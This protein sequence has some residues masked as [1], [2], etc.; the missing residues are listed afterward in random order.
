MS[1]KIDQRIVEMSFENAK[2]EKGIKQSQN[3]LKEFSKALKNSDINEDFA[4]L[5]KSVSSLSGHFSMLEQIGIGALRRIGEQAVDAGA[6][7]IKSLSVDQLAAGWNK[8]EEK[9]DAVQTLISAGYDMTAVNQQMEQLMWFSDETSYS[10]SDMSN[11]MG[12]FVAA[13]VDL[14]TS[15]RAMQGIATWAAH[16]GKNSQ[17][18]SIAM[19]NLSQAI[20]MGYVDTL[21]WRSIM[22]QNMNTKMF[23]EIAIG[24]AE[25]TGAIKEGQVTIQNFDSNL[26]DKWFTNDVLLKTLEQYSMYAEKVREVQEEMGFDTAN[27]AMEYMEEHGEE[28]ADVLSQIGNAAFK[29]AQESKKFSDSIAATM[30]AVSSGWMRTYEII[31]GEL[32]EAKERFT[33]LTEI[34]WTVFASGAEHRNEMLLWLKEAGGITN[35][36]QG[37]KNVAVALLKILKPISTAMDQIFPPKTKEQWLAITEAFKDFTNSLIIS[38]E[39]ADKVRRTFAGFFAVVDIGYRVLKFLGNA[40]L[41]LA[42]VF[43][44]LGSSFLDGTAS[45]GDFLVKIDELLKSSQLLNYALLAVKVGVALLRNGVQSVLSTI[46]EFVTGL[47]NAEDPLQYLADAGSTVFSGLIDGIKMASSWLTGKLSKALKTVSDL[48]KK[49]EGEDDSTFWSDILTVLKDIVEYIGGKG[50]EAFENFGETIKNL[51]F[52][53]IATFVVGGVLLILVKQISDLTGAMTGMTTAV[54]GAINAFTKKFL[55]YKT[56]T[57][58]RD[59]GYA[60]GI[61]A[62]SIWLLSK[63]PAEELKKSLLG[64]AAAMGIFVTA[65]GLLTG[66]QVAASKLMKNTEMVTSGFGLVGVAAALVVMAIALE[67]IAKINGESVWN[68]T[69]VL[70][71]MMGFILAYQ[72]L[73][74]V[75]ST[76]PNQQKV[77]MNLMGMSIAILTLVGTLGLLKEFTLN[78][79][80]DGLVKMTAILAVISALQLLF[81]VAARIGGGNKVSVSFIGVAAGVTAMVAVMA[82]LAAI[83][84]QTIS[85]GIGN[86]ALITLL[87]ASVEIVMGVAGRIDGDKK[88]QTNILKTTLGLLAMIGLVKV[89]SM[90]TDEEL[91]RGISA[92]AKMVAIVGA[93][94]L[95]TA[96]SARLA[97]GAKVQKILGSVSI[98]LL[99]FTGVVA[100]LGG[101]KD[102]VID[103]GIFTL[104]KM[105]GLI[106]AIEVVTAVAARASAIAEGSKGS[107]MFGN[108]IGVVAAVIALTM[109]VALLSMIDQ[110]S[111]RGAVTS[112]A[113]ASVAIGAL[114]IAL[115]QMFKSLNLISKGSSGFVDKVKN[116]GLMLVG[117]GAL[118]TATVGFFAALEIVRPWLEK[119]S[120]ETLTKFSVGLGAITVLLIAL[121]R[122]PMNDKSFT[123][124]LLS[125][126]PGFAAAAGIVL[127]TMGFFAALNVVL[128]IVENVSWESLGKFALGLGTVTALFVAMSLLGTPLAALGVFAGPV[129]TG[130]L[131]AI[132]GVTGIVLATVGLAELLNALISDKDALINGIDLL[133]Q[134][135]AGIG[136]FIGG[137]IGGLVGGTLEGAGYALANF[138]SSM[139]GFDPS[140]VESVKNLAEAVLIITGASIL[141]GIS[142]FFNLGKSSM[143]VFGDQLAGL[144]TAL[145]V[146]SPENA[147]HAS[148]VLAAM[149]PMAENLGAFAT[150]AQ[151][152]PNSGGFIGEFMGNNDIDTFGQMLGDFVMVF[153]TIKVEDATHMTAVL[154]AMEPMATNLKSFANVA[155]KIP[156]SGG[157]IGEF[158]GENDID[159]FG[160]MLV[161]FVTAFNA[162]TPEQA[163]IASDVLEAMSPM[164]GN[165]KEFAAAA[166]EIPAA[167]G[168][169]GAFLGTVDLP[170]FSGQIYGLIETFGGVDQTQLNTATETLNLMTD[171]ML[172]ALQK[173][174][175]FTNGLKASG[176]LAQLFTG[177]TTL[178]EFGAE[179]KSFIDTLVGADFTIVAPAMEAMADITSSFNVLGEDV[180]VNATESFENNKKPFQ[181]SI[182]TILDAPIAEI[183]KKK[184]SL[185][186]AITG[187]LSG[188]IDEGNTYKTKFN[189]LGQDIVIGLKNGI[190]AQKRSA[191]NAV[192]GVMTSVV[193]AAKTTVDSNSPSKVFETIGGWCD[194]GLANGLKKNTDVAVK[195]G[196]NMASATEEGVRDTLG[197]HSLSQLFSDI[198]GWIPT[199]ITDG[200]QNGTGGLVDKA[201]SMGLGVSGVITDTLGEGITEGQGGI[202]EKIDSLLELLT[203]SSSPAASTAA[204]GGKDLGNAVTGGFQSALTNSSTGIGGSKS[205]AAVKSELDKLKSIIEKRQF[206]GTIS[207]QQEL[208]LYQSLRN[209][210]KVGSKERETIDREIYTRLQTIYNAQTEYIEGV[211]DAQREAAEERA[212]LDKEYYEGVENAKAEANKKLAQL[213]SQYHNDVLQAKEDAD[214]RRADEDE[215]YFTNLNSILD[216]AEADR[217]S[218][219]EQYADNQKSINERLLSDIEAQ[220]KAYE[221]AVKSR[222]DAIYGS[223]N[224]FDVVEEDPEITGDELLKNLQDQGAAISEWRQ[225]LD[226][227]QARGVSDALIE[228]IQ[229]MGPAS[230][231]QIKAL[232][233][234]TDEQLDEYVS[235]FEGKYSLSRIRAE[236]ELE[237]LKESTNQAI[238]DLNAQAAVDLDN[239]TNEFN[240]TMSEIND[241]MATDL[242]DLK[243]AHEETLAEI[244]S[245][246]SLKLAELKSTWNENS[247]AVQSDLAE[248]LA[249]LEKSYSDSM[250][251]VNSDLKTKL[252]DMK[253]QYDEAMKTV[254][255]LTEEELRKLI[256]ENKTQLETLNTDTSAKLT[257]VQKTYENGAANIVSKFGTGLAKILPNTASTLGTMLNNSKTTLNGANGSFN[258]AGYNAAAGFANGIRSGTYRVISAAQYMAYSAKVAAERELDENSPSKIFAGIG[259]FVSLGFANGITDYAYKA[260]SASKELASGPIDAVAEA[261]AEME[262]NDDL[263]FTI[264]PIIDLSNVR[265]TDIAQLL[266]TP[267]Q[268]GQTSAKLA[269]EVDQNGNRPVAETTQIVNKFDCTGMVVREEADIDR[270]A[271]KLYQKQQTASRGRGVRAPAR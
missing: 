143:E 65:Y 23:K 242:S 33:A 102:E 255:G 38:D 15:S 243:T 244:N 190:L 153:S 233:T 54:S 58:I 98:A 93:I 230:K 146:I 80:Q 84:P 35:V 210:Y 24:V 103:Q 203:D 96:A 182:S 16:S 167:G 169:I 266:R 173:F 135:G 18:A 261:L 66:I 259:K 89:L 158:M 116:I 51:D 141:D 223:Y 121:D 41:E 180:I 221:D 26:K 218:I 104:T 258:N 142:R 208:D 47:W 198:G 149:K 136:R 172:P 7:L 86:L 227:L 267:V 97:N 216:K 112:L 148:E 228:E 265:S 236:Q 21:N 29:S 220:N 83:S 100:I 183:D 245:D 131:V 145:D 219:R 64:L 161:G 246:L 122:V 37:F 164:A 144:V 105:V 150:V 137:A 207:V 152:I 250:S 40:A 11:N 82:L 108:L 188:A 75:I 174:S 262:D 254:K 263:E 3:S 163:Q 22:N 72:L 215:S 269:A 118:L 205:Q 253:K 234:L 225:S 124:R 248:N 171:T 129:L 68:A 69:A 176:G 192:T 14:E 73:S 120:W 67:T 48:F 156:N 95:F 184:K 229:A 12:K 101:M 127:G 199:S 13:G 155:Q 74:S 91:S 186:D 76:I 134:V 34:L 46:R 239:L 178:S 241:N 4:G 60:L 231:A 214:Q 201:K 168:F 206:Y 177:N 50:T 59:M 42:K 53:K 217:Q 2:F 154:A 30:D 62:A 25:A 179:L 79:I 87:L 195:A 257:A 17:A 94:E 202:S 132:A 194:K 32:D 119:V 109:S 52:H 44:P 235:L 128:P 56:T 92:L 115:S 191:V 43:L 193:T 212:Q 78:D 204:S 211:R 57:N 71:A 85:K 187:A 9:I 1:D 117:V 151:D 111:L 31:F 133:V 70:G 271:A 99:A 268:L 157:F 140:T 196:I 8:Y 10:F 6:R 147:T 126:I 181:A 209:Q 19:F 113:I 197:V 185:T 251:K 200:I 55:G 39:T 166:Q 224:L 232:L 90:M 165:L 249:S 130:A 256:A 264:T 222:A 125:L 77:S 162:V 252:D 213:D 240:T 107:S 88:P 81:S 27:Q 45:L 110:E 226:E 61:L 49:L 138:V 160:T 159:T 20:S 63:I 238:K 270:I 175:D 36:F 170:T 247:A 106:A 28:Y 237:G 5:D 189:K 260:V 114:S 123:S 139:Q